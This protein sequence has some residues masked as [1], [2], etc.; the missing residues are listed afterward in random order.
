TGAPAKRQEAHDQYDSE[1]LAKALDEFRYR[2]VDYMGLVG[3][4]GNLNAD[5][6]LRRD[7]LHRLLQVLAERDDV[8]AVRHRDAEPEGR[9][10]AFAHDEC[11]RGLI[12]ALDCGGVGEAG[13]TSPR[14]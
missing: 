10:A 1:R 3:D 14:P 12:A 2:F 7:R 8:R 4:L 5:R 11:R 6:Q 13:Q 9:L